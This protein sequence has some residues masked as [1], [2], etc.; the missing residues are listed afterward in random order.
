M[1]AFKTIMGSARFNFAAHQGL[2]GYHRIADEW[3]ELALSLGDA[4]AFYHEPE[5]I[6]A[7]LESGACDPDSVWL[8]TAR[9]EG[10]LVAVAPLQYQ[11][12]RIGPFTPRLLGTIEDDQ[13]QLSDFVFR[14]AHENARFMDELVQWLK[15]GS[16]LHWDGLRLRRVRE[17]AAIRYAASHALPRNTQVLQHAA[18]SYFDTRADFEHATRAM[19][20]HFRRNLRRQLRRSEE[21]WKV[22]AETASSGAALQHAFEQFL[23]IEASGW[24]GDEGSGSAIHCQPALLGFYQSLVRHFGARGECVINLLWFGEQAVAGEFALKT[25]RTLHVLKCGYREE[26]AKYA[27][28]NVLLQLMIQQACEDVGTDMLSLVNDPPWSHRFK[29]LKTGVWSYFIPNTTLRGHLTL[30][31]LLGKRAMD[32]R[33]QPPVSA[34]PEEAEEAEA[35]KSPE[36]PAVAR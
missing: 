24:K 5:W 10:A 31:G 7:F 16:G 3:R 15:S 30:W 9:R 13:L 21:A 14:Q 17:D 18:S 28:G 36:N 32:R 2:H 1:R 12:Y 6:L 27:P 20:Y 35:S 23:K 34:T 25:G 26:H 29:P 11:D 4:C 19:S 8:V 22:R 33:R